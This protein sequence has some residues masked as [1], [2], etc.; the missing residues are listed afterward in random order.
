MSS[1]DTVVLSGKL[2]LNLFSNPV[3]VNGGELTFEVPHPPVP[4]EIANFLL[5]RDWR[6]DVKEH[7]YSNISHHNMRWDEAMAIEFY[8]FISLGGR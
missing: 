5:S 4:L 3:Q 6:Y 8:E 7:R 2:H 1:I